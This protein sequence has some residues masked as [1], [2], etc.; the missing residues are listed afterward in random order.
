MQRQIKP[1]EWIEDFIVTQARRDADAAEDLS[2]LHINTSRIR[3]DE[4]GCNWTVNSLANPDGHV[5]YVWQIVAAEKMLYN[6]PS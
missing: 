6:L 4:T 1:R 5:Q 3:P 2:D